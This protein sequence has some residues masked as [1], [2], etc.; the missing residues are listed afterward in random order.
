MIRSLIVT[1]ICMLCIEFVASAMPTTYLPAD[2][3]VY[4][5]LERLEQRF[6]ESSIYLGTRPMTRLQAA[7]Y[8]FGA[9]IHREDMTPVERDEFDVYLDEFAPDMSP[10]RSWYW[11]SEGPYKRL[12]GVLNDYF[13]GNGRNFFS[14]SGYGYSLYFDPVIVR[15]YSFVDSPV[16]GS[17]DNVHIASNG[18]TLYGGIGNH[19]GYHIDVRD[20]REWGSREYPASTATTLPGIGFASFKDD[21][22]EYDETRAHLLFS[23]GPFGIMLGRDTNIWGRGDRSLMF[24]GYGAPYDMLRIDTSFWRIRFVS[25][26]AEIEQYPAIADFY[27]PAPAGVSPDSVAVKKYL[28]GHRIEINITDRFSLGLHEAVVY[29][30]RWDVA[31][32]NPVMFYK[33]AEHANGDHDNSLMGMDMNLIMGRGMS[34]YGELLIDDITTTKLGTD[35]YGNKLAF[36]AG[37]Y[38][39]DPPLLDDGDIRIEYTRL[40]P[41]V[42]THRYPIDSF[43]HYGDVLGHPAGPNSDVFLIALRKRF[44]RRLNAG[45]MVTH[46]RHGENTETRNVGGDPLDGFSPGDS[47]SASFLAGDLAT[48][49]ALTASVSYEILWRL[50]LKASVTQLNQDGETVHRFGFSMSFNE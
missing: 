2:H 15:D 21:H 37:M 20:S 42:Y 38:T 25:F 35:W 26:A 4:D 28:S 40:N 34:I 19:L 29:G 12:P 18:F 39:V 47:K 17:E 13:Y 27:Y 23:G 36:Q 14:A 16:T 6:P 46:Y 11:G 31:Y 45:V 48:A 8:L 22:A 1:V 24:S 5:F 10:G 9:V 3:P 49:T 33:G 44:T 7:Q 43:T 41:W 30:G 50:F 32:L